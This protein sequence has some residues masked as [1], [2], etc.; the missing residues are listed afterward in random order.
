MAYSEQPTATRWRADVNGL[1]T[2][3]DVLCCYT[4]SGYG[5]AMI[6]CFTFYYIGVI[7]G[8]CWSG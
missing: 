5:Y 6:G 8:E 1:A 2:I 3:S 7:G 4:N